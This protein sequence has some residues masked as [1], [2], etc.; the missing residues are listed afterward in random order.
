MTKLC[1]DRRKRLA[2]YEIEKGKHST[3]KIEEQ[4]IVDESLDREFIDMERTAREANA[5][6][7]IKSDTL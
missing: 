6:P 4:R 3:R 5:T 2:P 7:P 1:L